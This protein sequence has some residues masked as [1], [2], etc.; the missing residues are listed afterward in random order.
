MLPTYC[1]RKRYVISLPSCLSKWLGYRRIYAWTTSWERIRHLQFLSKHLLRQ[2]SAKSVNMAFTS[3]NSPESFPQKSGGKKHGAQP[4]RLEPVIQHAS[5]LPKPQLLFKRKHD[6]SDSPWR[7]TLSHKYNAK[8]P[9]G[10]IYQDPG[11]EHTI[12]WVYGTLLNYLHVH[13]NFKLWSSI[14]I[15]DYPPILSS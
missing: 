7:P 2:R 14:S 5:T 1:W 4:G 11:M 8:V 9:L 6:N 13:V 12:V 15:W 3:W 10:Y